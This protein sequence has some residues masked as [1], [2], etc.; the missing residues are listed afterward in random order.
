M[1]LTLE[2]YPSVTGQS[3][4]RMTV[5]VCVSVHIR[6]FITTGMIIIV[7]TIDSTCASRRLFLYVATC[8][9]VMFNGACIVRNGGNNLCGR[10]L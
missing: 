3:E 9:S 8:T 2:Q 7:P 10:L 4:N 1:V 6:N 5:M